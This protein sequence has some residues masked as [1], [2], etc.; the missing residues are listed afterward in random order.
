MPGP[1]WGEDSPQDETRIASNIKVVLRDVVTNAARRESP[2]IDLAKHWHRDIYRGTSSPPKP[3][4]LGA[5]RG[6]SDPDLRDYQVHLVSTRGRI[7]ASGAPPE[8][9]AAELATFERSMQAS[10]V[11]LDAA[12]PVGT[13]PVDTRQVLGVVELA[14]VAHGEWVRIHPF[15]NG[16]GRT[17][18]TWANWVAVRYGLPPFVRIKPRPDGLLYGQAAHLSM[19]APPATGPDHTLTVQVFLDLLRQRP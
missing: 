17:A 18:R 16:N 10:V 11:S 14:A 7:L 4:Y 13:S 5:L 2:T 3:S 6:S 8:Q 1:S 15:A 12:I 19:G 9:V